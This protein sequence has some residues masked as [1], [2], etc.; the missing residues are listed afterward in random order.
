MSCESN[1]PVIL[2]PFTAY[3]FSGSLL[4]LPPHRLYHYTPAYNWQNPDISDAKTL[5]YPSQFF[6]T[7]VPVHQLDGRHSVFGQLTEDMDVLRSITLRDPQ[8]NPGIELV[9]L[10]YFKMNLYLRGQK[11]EKDFGKWRGISL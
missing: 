4:G 9:R 5:A 2:T 1:I 3:L 6:T 11:L 7:Y 8:Q 10:L